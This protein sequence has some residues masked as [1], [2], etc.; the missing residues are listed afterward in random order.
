ML[1]GVSPA[2][3]AYGNIPSAADEE[4]GH[5]IRPLSGCRTSEANLSDQLEVPDDAKRYT[6]AIHRPCL[7]HLLTSQH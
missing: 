1:C 2:L 3:T 4:Y 7:E 5:R 6:V